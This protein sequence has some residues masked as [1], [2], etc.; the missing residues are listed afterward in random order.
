MF[1]G[2]KRE[3]AAL[4]D[5]YEVDGFRMS[6][7]YGRR[8][9][10]K[11]E[12]LNHFSKNKEVIFF[13]ASESSIENNL[14]GFENAVFEAFSSGGIHP[15]FKSFEEAFFYIG[16][17]TGKKKLLVI[18]D[19]YPYL[20]ETD[21]SISSVLQKCIDT[22]WN[23]KNIYLILCG[24]SVSFMEDEVLAGKSPLY[25][26]RT[27]QMDV[28]PFDYKISSEFVPDYTFEEKA[29]VYG[30]TGGVAK[31][32]ALFDPEKNLD[33]NIKRLFFSESGYLFEEPK[34]LL[35]QEFRDITLYNTVIEAIA[36]GANKMNEISG[37]TGI[38]TSGLSQAL[39]K[40][41]KVRIIKKFIPILNEKNKRYGGYVVS[42]GMFRFWYRFGPR[43]IT[44]VTRGFGAQYYDNQ[45]K[46]FI[47][48]YMGYVF[49]E[50]CQEYVMEQ[51]ISGNL[52]VFTSETGKWTG[53]DNERKQPSDIDV[54][55]IDRVNKQAVIGECK[56]RNKPVDKEEIEALY[57]RRS[58]IMPYDV[59]EIL[60]FSL[61]GYEKGAKKIAG[62]LGIKT[63]VID[64][65]Y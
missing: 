18:I 35:R 15:H 53:H 50:M 62:G 27:S 17:K 56:F 29:V 14:I 37:K 36:G 20:A 59:K 5:E 38:S 13:T 40:L 39:N 58:L 43:G 48:E 51:G 12:L 44:A 63:F 47:H 42:D 45:V 16:E 19:E 3:L 1:L 54:V 22:S 61:A 26:R 52:G 25:G 32:L 57:K 33:D 21:K 46:P 8:R 7:L 23:K 10:G 41:I 31:Y 64:E 34:N 60:Y 55:G 24:S 4:Q 11:T 6:V 2:R 9:V 28:R 49:E 30:I 65:I